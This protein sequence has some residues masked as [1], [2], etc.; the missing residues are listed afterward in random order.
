VKVAPVCV[1]LVFDDDGDGS[2][3]KML[4]CSLIL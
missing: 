3:R 2:H 1:F 4:A